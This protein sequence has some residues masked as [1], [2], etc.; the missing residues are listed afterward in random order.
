VP[1]EKLV[2]ETPLEIRGAASKE[3]AKTEQSWIKMVAKAHNLATTKE[4]GYPN[5]HCQLS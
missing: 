3:N 1:D 4:E 2:A 5:I